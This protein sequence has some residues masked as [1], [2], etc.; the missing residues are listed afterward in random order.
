M[1]K[2]ERNGEEAV[3]VCF[4]AFTEGSEENHEVRQDIR[5]PDRD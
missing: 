4:T 2:L 1:L 5:C 3:M